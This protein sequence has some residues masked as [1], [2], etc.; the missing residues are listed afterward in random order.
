MFAPAVTVNDCA[1]VGVMNSFSGTKTT[2]TTAAR[3]INS[4]S[5]H[6]GLEA[7]LSD[8][9]RG[10]FTRGYMLAPLRGW[11]TTNDTERSLPP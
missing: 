11:P 7:L 9:L 10:A 5:P 8:A 4:L 3:P 2:V 6:A 1:L